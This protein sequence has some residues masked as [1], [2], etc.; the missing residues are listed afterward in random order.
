MEFAERTGLSSDAPPRRYLWTDAFAVCNFIGL[1]RE[2]GEQRYAQL[3]LE[4]IEQVHHVLGTY[5]SDDSRTGWI[6]GLDERDAEAH[7]T[8][9]G[10]RIGKPLPERGALDP[11]DERLEW[12]RDGQYFH[13]S[14]KWMHALNQTARWTGQPRYNSWAR[15]PRRG[16]P[17]R[18]HVFRRGRA[19]HGVED[20]HR[21][22]PAAR[23]VHGPPRSARRLHHLYRAADDS[24]AVVEL[25]RFWRRQR[26]IS[27]A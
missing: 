10:L 20:E 18:L 26:P 15:E 24:L 23:P 16:K 7:P 22:L 14:T 5:R 25:G 6:S 2:T 8:L 3:A 19:T 13:Y 4:L 17:R 11:F 9:G 1:A 27:L 21:P 12:Q